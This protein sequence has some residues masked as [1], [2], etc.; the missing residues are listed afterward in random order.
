MVSHHRFSGFDLSY[1]IVSSR[2][3]VCRIDNA[4]NQAN[5]GLYPCNH[6]DQLHVQSLSNTR[7]ITD[8]MAFI[9]FRQNKIIVANSYNLVR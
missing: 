6:A 7:Y 9:T 4:C 2:T 1:R 5:F 8:Q 3:L